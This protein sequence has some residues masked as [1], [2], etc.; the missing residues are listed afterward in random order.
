MWSYFGSKSKIAKHYPPPIYDTIIE[1]FAG[2]AKYSLYRNNW[3]KNII[4]VDAYEVIC[5]IWW[6]L[7]KA[8][9]NDILSLPDIS[10][11][12]LVPDYLC[13]EE[14]WLM[15]FCV[16]R[17]TTYPRKRASNHNSW[18]RDKVRIANNL[19]K[20][21]HW[22]IIHGSYTDLENQVA[23]WFIDPPYQE[24]GWQYKANRI[25][26]AALA[27]WC[28]SRTGQVIVCENSTANWLD[29]KPLVPMKGTKYT[30]TE[31]IWYKES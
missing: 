16:N 31:C 14:K 3:E 24:Q 28:K 13:D 27:E 10:K 22:K 1:P 15:G 4:L 19:H 5:R 18:D 12:E 30:T 29:F 25:D 11:G 21:R 26:Y 9:P 7:Q 20:I 6:Y 2:T 23:T 8:S 17:G